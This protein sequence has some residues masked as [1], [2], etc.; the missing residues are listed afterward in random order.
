MH[1]NLLNCTNVHFYVV[2]NYRLII[3]H[4]PSKPA[5]QVWLAERVLM[6]SRQ[7]RGIGDKR[8]IF[9]EGIKKGFQVGGGGGGS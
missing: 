1:T 9:G 4:T 5:C 8:S 2:N 3:L 7:R 6:L